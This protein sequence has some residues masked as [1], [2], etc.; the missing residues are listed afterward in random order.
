MVKILDAL[1]QGVIVV[2]PDERISLM[3]SAA[4]RILGYSA[5]DL[6]QRWTSADW[7]TV[8]EHGGQ[9]PLEQRPARRALDTGLP[10]TGQIV[11]WRRNDD[12][13]A[14]LRVSC[15]PDVDGADSLLIAFVD[16][17]EDHLA[18]RLLDVTFETAPVGLAVIGRDRRIQRCNSTFATQAGRLAEELIGIDA[19]DLIDAADAE[20]IR[21]LIAVFTAGEIDDCEIEH[22]VA[23]DDGAEVSVNS[24]IASIPS[25]GG[26]WAAVAAVFDVTARRQ[27]MLELS[28]YRHLFTNAS[29]IVVVLDADARVQLVS[30]STERILGYPVGYRHAGG[31][32]G[33]VHPQDRSIAIDALRQLIDEGSWRGESVTV[34]VADAA[35]EWRFVECVGANLLDVAEVHRPRADDPRHH[36]PRADRPAALPPGEP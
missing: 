19:I 14:L 33:L 8:D 5:E 4:T 35:G 22:R 21:R 36:R 1:E 2:G 27:M 3:N 30:P 25:V 7:L 32:F 15:L 18:K 28:R 6:D 34:R 13:L 11:G 31:V 23:R 26:R 29:D 24:R 20:E 12:R 16:I 17:T 9:L 10:V